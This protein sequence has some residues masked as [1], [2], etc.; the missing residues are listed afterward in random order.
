LVD[1][2]QRRKLDPKSDEGI[3]VGYS[4]NSRVY[5][6]YNKRTM[7]IMELINVISDPSRPIRVETNPTR[8][9]KKKLHPIRFG[10]A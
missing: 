1:R 4:P 5:R 9:L 7:T 8:E 3:F 6:V 2:E 10:F